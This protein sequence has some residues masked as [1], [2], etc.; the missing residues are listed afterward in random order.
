M[1]NSAIPEMVHTLGKHWVQPERSE[2]GV[3]KVYA[4]MLKEAFDK[5]VEYSS[6]L[7]NERESS[8]ETIVHS[9]NATL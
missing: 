7:W 8:I 6:S 4:T 3:G 9:P 2:I 1:S 5:L